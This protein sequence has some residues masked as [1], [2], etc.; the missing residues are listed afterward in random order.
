MEN[1][2]IKL[3]ALEPEDIDLL[4][5]WEND[6][7]LWKVSNT[8]APFSRNTLRRYIENAHDDIYDAKQLRLMIVDKETNKTVGCIDLFDFEPFHLRAGVGILVYES[9]DRRKGFAKE[10]LNLLIEYCFTHLHFHQ[11]Y[12]NITDD[13]D[14]SIKLFQNAGFVQT[15]CK[16]DWLKYCNEWKNELIFQ[17]VNDNTD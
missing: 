16:I 8:L 12:C 7:L 17:L 1:Q 5:T 15:G 13:N 14:A 3:R 4:Y 2:L 11:L 6:T 9:E 10:A